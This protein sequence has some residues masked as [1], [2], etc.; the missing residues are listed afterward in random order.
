MKSRLTPGGAA[1]IALVAAIACEPAADTEAGESGPQAAPRHQVRD[2]AGIRIIENRRPADGSRLGWEIGAEPAFTI[3]SVEASEGF[4]LH[5][6]DDALR[7][8][9]GRLV[10]ANGG[11]H[12]LLV[13]DEGCTYLTAWGQKGEGPGD[14]GGMWAGNAFGRRLF[15][16]EPWPGDSIAVCHGTF[17]W[18]LGLFSVFG[19]DGRHA[20]TVNLAPDGS[21]TRCREVLPD[22]AIIVTRSSPWSGFLPTGTR[23]DN[24]DFLILEG[25]GSLRTE[26]GSHPGAEVF[27]YLDDTVIPPS[28]FLMLDPPFQ[29][30]VVWGAWG[31]L[32]IVSPTDRYE[33]RAFGADGSVARIVRRD[34]EVRTPTQADLDRFRADQLASYGAEYKAMI[35]PVLDGLSVPPSFPA[36]SSIEVDALGYLWVREFNLPGEQGTL[37]T[38]FDPDGIVQGFVETPPDLEI[39]EI[40]E[41][42]IVGKARD[43]LGVEYVQLWELARVGA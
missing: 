4:Q 32:A 35:T 40:G 25:D 15:W 39:Y 6:V 41:D 13:F 17:S 27:D 26:L 2:S 43:E 30:T 28:T 9:D 16:A 34:H 12:Q 7:L 8:G 42:Y 22:G 38:V 1:A 36:F 33:I 20:R 29:Q 5:Q 24:L 18:G 31:D 37:W 3:G 19:P 21:N 14:F 11:S 10:V 23:R